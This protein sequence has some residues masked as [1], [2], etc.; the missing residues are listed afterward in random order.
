MTT[1]EFLLWMSSIDTQGV[2]MDPSQGQGGLG[3][4]LKIGFSKQGTYSLLLLLLSLLSLLF[5]G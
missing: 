1:Y 2:C 5:K 3:G 4:K